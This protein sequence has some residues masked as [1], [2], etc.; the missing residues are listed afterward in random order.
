MNKESLLFTPSNIGPLTLRNRSIRAAAFEGMCPGNRPSKMLIDYHRSVAAGGIG[1]TTVAYASVTRDGLSFPH[2]LW[3]RKE[4]IPELRTLTDAIHREGA[5]ASIQLGHCGN[6]SKSAV[7]GRMPLSPSGGLNIY[8]PTWSKKMNKEE[9]AR[10]AAAY[11][12]AVNIARESGFDAVEVH[13]GHG[14]LISQ[15]L[16]PYT[17]HRKDEFGGSLENR[18][19]F[20]QMAMRSVISAAGNDMG[21][22]V[23]MNMNDG[24]RGGMQTDECLEVARTLEQEGAHALVL[25]GGFVSRAPMYVMRGSMPIK[26][27]TY[28]MKNIPL[29]L[30]VK[31]AG[32]WMI[33]PVPFREAYFLEDALKFRQEVKLP[34]VYVGGLISGKKIDEVLDS[35]FEFVSMARALLNEP[36]FI[37]RLKNDRQAVNQCICANYCIARMYSIE[38]ACHQHRSDVPKCLHKELGIKK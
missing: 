36:D 10:I 17:N 22:V 8:S 32:R 9:I 19:R 26:T 33:R 3:L 21:V 2:Q 6:M 27:L 11:G 34:L 31:I 29:K 25:S 28:Y 12:E 5:A 13:A 20:M 7:A 30:G 35:G 24:F 4:I 23:K 18:M 1:M 37:N 38:M 15:F 14:Y 16:S